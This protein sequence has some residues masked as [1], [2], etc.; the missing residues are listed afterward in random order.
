MVWNESP[1]NRLQPY[2][3]ALHLWESQGSAH[4]NCKW[5]VSPWENHLSDKGISPSQYQRGLVWGRASRLWT[6]STSP[7]QDFRLQSHST[8]SASHCPDQACHGL[9]WPRPTKPGLT[10]LI[11]PDVFSC[12]CTVL[13]SHLPLWDKCKWCIQDVALFSSSLYGKDQFPLRHL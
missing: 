10:Q 6:N 11:V 12:V 4:P 13:D 1:I 8:G 2:S 9:Y 7:G 3:L 5:W